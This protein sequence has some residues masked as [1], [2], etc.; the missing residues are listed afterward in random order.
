MIALALVLA[1]TVSVDDDPHVR[2]VLADPAYAFCHD[3][4]FPLTDDEARWCPLLE[5]HGAPACPAFVQ[6]CGATRAEPNVFEGRF[7][8]RRR[9]PQPGEPSTRGDGGGSSRYREREQRDNTLPDFGGL[10]GL[11][12]WT[13][14]VG[15]AIVVAWMISK[16][17]GGRAA[18]PTPLEPDPAMPAVGEPGEPVD[19]RQLVTDVEALLRAASE[20]ESRGELALAVDLGH[21]ALLRRLY[22]EGVIHLHRAR[23]HGDYLVDL[24]EHPRWRE[25]IRAVFREVDRV[26]FGASVPEPT[27]VRGILV[28]IAELARTGIAPALLLLFVFVATIACD[29]NQSW[30]WRSSPSGNDGVIAWLRKGGTEVSWRTDALG[31]LE[32][33][34]A[35][36]LLEGSVLEESEWGAVREWVRGGGRLVLAGR[37]DTPAWID[38]RRTGGPYSEISIEDE[39]WIPGDASIDS[40]AFGTAPLIWRGHAAY[41]IELREGA[42]IVVALADHHLFTNA[43]LAIG[44]SST[45][46]P[47]VLG[48]R[49]RVEL[50]D[51]WSDAGAD[52]PLESIRD[53]HLTAAIAQL[54]LLLLA[55]YLWR[56]W[57]FGRLREPPPPVGRGFADHARAMGLQYERARAEHHAAGVYS[58]Y[59]LETL[60]REAAGGGAGLHG[61]A[62][63]LARRTGRDE[64][65]LMRLLVEIH[66]PSAGIDLATVRELARLL[67]QT[68]R[69]EPRGAPPN[70]GST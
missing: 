61:L 58:S 11:L 63:S 8:A 59:A 25:P 50:V 68:A 9:D 49:R 19:A 40:T 16:N 4:S 45:W 30:P 65:E 67:Q 31:E 56:G 24:R 43:A 55:L 37:V 64:T 7:T 12:F 28:R 36:V 70:R 54:M 13:V 6:T 26:Q 33:G 23:T 44:A 14:I 22:H 18:T 27:Q 48:D 42:G 32:P 53:S 15:A 62:Q 46:L 35:I 66:D 52:T 60:R 41:A 38:T 20:A 57:P 69:H 1:A 39:P 17:L 29:E 2:E 47:S 5:Q 51:A 34:G 3:P 10:P 21:A